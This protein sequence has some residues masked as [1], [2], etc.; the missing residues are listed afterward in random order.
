[1]MEYLPICDGHAIFE[2][3]ENKVTEEITEIELTPAVKML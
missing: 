2:D 1:M 3:E